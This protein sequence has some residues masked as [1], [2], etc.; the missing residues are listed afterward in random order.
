L[1]I[2]I[3]IANNFA[4]FV[5]KIEPEQVDVIVGRA[6]EPLE[7]VLPQERVLFQIVELKTEVV[8]EKQL[9][10]TVVPRTS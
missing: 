6:F 3:K 4:L 10:F 2:I 9:A 1:I 5:F 8:V 7:A